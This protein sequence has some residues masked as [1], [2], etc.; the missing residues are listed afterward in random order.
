MGIRGG[1]LGVWLSLRRNRRSASEVERRRLLALLAPCDIEPGL[2]E[3]CSTFWESGLVAVFSAETFGFRWVSAIGTVPEGFGFC[4]NP[5]AGF[6]LSKPEP[7]R[8]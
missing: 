4:E 6:S 7:A 2:F 1:E 5:R 3:G 8:G